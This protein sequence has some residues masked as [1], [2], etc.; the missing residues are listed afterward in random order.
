MRLPV[1]LVG[2]GPFDGEGVVAT[3][4]KLMPQVDHF[5][6]EQIDVPLH[7]IDER[8]HVVGPLYH[9]ETDLSHRQ[10]R[11]QSVDVDGGHGGQFD[12]CGPGVGL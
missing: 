3:C 10:D 9:F 11:S 7:F 1:E 12:V 6:G 2:S 8:R 5:V 4:L